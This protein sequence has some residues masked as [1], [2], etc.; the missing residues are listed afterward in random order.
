M[1]DLEQE[2]DAPNDKSKDTLRPGLS[3]SKYLIVINIQDFSKEFEEQY[4]KGVRSFIET[5]VSEFIKPSKMKHEEELLP[6]VL[7]FDKDLHVYVNISDINNLYDKDISCQ[8][9]TSTFHSYK[10]TFNVACAL[11]SLVFGCFMYS[12]K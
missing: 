8:K 7:I 12:Q 1:K 5:D 10:L 3:L 2:V 4:K 11:E 9:P 6:F